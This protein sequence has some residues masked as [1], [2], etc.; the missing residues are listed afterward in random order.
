MKKKI[1]L[2]LL[3]VLA[4]TVLFSGAL[5]AVPQIHGVGDSHGGFTEWNTANSLPASSKQYYLSTDVTLSDN[6]VIDSKTIILCLN[7]HVVNLNG[8]HIEI[9]NGGNLM[10][11]DCNATTKHYFNK[12]ASGLWT[13]ASDQTVPTDYVVIGGVVTGGIATNGGAV[14]VSTSGLFAMAGGTLAGNKATNGGGIHI[15]TG[16]LTMTGGVITGNTASNGGG[17]HVQGECT[18]S[19]TGGVITGNTATQNG[20][21]VYNKR[22][23]TKVGG[24][25]RITGNLAGAAGS[26]KENNL[27]ISYGCNLSLASPK[28]GMCVGINM[29]S[30][31]IFVEP[32]S[33]PSSYIRYFRSDSDAYIVDSYFTSLKLVTP[34]SI[35][36][37]VSPTDYGVIYTDK[38]SYS[39]GNPFT[40]TLVPD[41]GCYL[42]EGTFV[43]TKD[44]TPV[45]TPVPT[46]DSSGHLIYKYTGMADGT[47]T[48]SAVFGQ[49]THDGEE[50]T[51]T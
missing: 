37:R 8:K 33:N 46:K 24:T 30:P 23:G 42:K 21:G 18:A 39:S 31:G 35:V 19:F 16:T 15:V 10:I 28:L 9:K 43:V 4:V 41:A 49:H 34:G 5:S 17:V 50:G 13:L 11:C 36:V 29:P 22:L 6:W 14:S 44:G 47:Y 25:V 12:D 7:G 32:P 1:I 45:A 20:G 38:Q 3:T 40:L 27:F 48:V 51:Y 26:R 2:V